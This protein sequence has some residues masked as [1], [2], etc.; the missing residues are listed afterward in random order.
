VSE[1]GAVIVAVRVTGTW[2]VAGLSAEVTVIVGDVLLQPV[3]NPTVTKSTVAK[4][5]EE[6]PR[7]LLRRTIPKH[8]N[9]KAALPQRR[10]PF[11]I[12][13][14]LSL[15]AAVAFRRDGLGETKERVT[16]PGDPFTDSVDGEKVQGVVAK[17][18]VLEQLKASVPLKPLT[19]V[20]VTTEVPVVPCPVI[21]IGVVVTVKIG[22]RGVV[23]VT[24][25]IVDCEG[26]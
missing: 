17:A 6:I 23:T 25:A 10:E 22:A 8:N 12:G 20:T 26:A 16:E 11:D 3:S 14:G 9:A 4:S 24:D 7:S 18:P 21:L 5:I 13:S 15:L 2:V 19:G 1:P